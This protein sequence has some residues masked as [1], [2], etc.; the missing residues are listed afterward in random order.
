MQIVGFID[1]YLPI[2]SEPIPGVPVLSSSTS[3]AFQI[4]QHD[5]DTVIVA[6][7][8]MMREQL[9]SL[10]STLDTFQDVEVRLASGLFELLTTSVRVREEGFV[11]LLVLNKNAD[12]RHPFDCQNGARL[13][14]G[15]HGAD[16]LDPLLPCGR[17]SHQ[18]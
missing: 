2:G 14:P 6:N 15:C 3:F 18:A 13:C 16:G 4:Q 12:H 8:A 11:P 17:L 1:D 5:I 7:T 9:L 10:Y